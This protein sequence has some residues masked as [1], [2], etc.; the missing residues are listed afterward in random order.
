MSEI[1]VST[2]IAASPGEVWAGVADIAGHVEWM[3]DAE[4]IR[5]TSD[6]THGV[7]T[8][9]D[10]DTKVG[11][12]RTTDRMEITEWIPGSVMGVRH[13]G[14]VTGD[15]RFSLESLGGGHTRFVWSE[16]LMFPWWV[17]GPIGAKAAAPVLRWIWNRNLTR[18]KAY[19][20]GLGD[21]GAQA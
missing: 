10:C 20:E 5:F 7:G 18:L 17:G 14:I 3:A 21:R 8:T 2:T 15:G 6:S 1:V 16:T 11:P 4:A 9:F 19:I 13:T 12:F